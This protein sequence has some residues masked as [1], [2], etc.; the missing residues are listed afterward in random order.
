MIRFA[1]IVSNCMQVMEEDVFLAQILITMKNLERT[2]HLRQPGYQKRLF[3][4]DSITVRMVQDC[5]T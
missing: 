4:M 2:K 3:A 5:A 1:I